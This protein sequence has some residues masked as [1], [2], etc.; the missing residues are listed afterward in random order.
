MHVLFHYLGHV[1][2]EGAQEGRVVMAG[3][4]VKLWV[5]VDRRERGG[6]GL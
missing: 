4:G 3:V 5:K 2:E 6:L 1:V